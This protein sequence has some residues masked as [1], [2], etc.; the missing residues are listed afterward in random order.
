MTKRGSLHVVGTGIRG[1]GQTTLEAVE[2]IKKADRVFY[3]VGERTT[4]LWLKSLNP[5]A[6]SLSDLY[7]EHKN[8]S[9]TYAEM[10]ER[11]TAAVR[12]GQRV[13]AV[14]Y[15]HPGVLVQ[16]THTA[17]GQ[18]RRAGYGAS[19]SP[20]VSADGCLFAELGVNPGDHGVQSFEATDFLLKRRRFDPTS[21]LLLWQVGVLGDPT[22]GT[23]RRPERLATLVRTLRRHYPESHR[24]VLY[25]A[26]TFPTRPSII[27]RLRLDRLPRAAVWPMATLYV[28]PLSQRP[29][30]QVVARWASDSHSPTD[31]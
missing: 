16:A 5:T 8:R 23:T 21:E 14:F 29:S 28:P 12:T 22:G 4:A 30:A 24:V 25:Y 18:L 10:V 19:M 1:I 7:G 15:G 31:R 20:G 2:Q 13:C 17:I 3:M 6:S 11:I 27:K 26:S 9:T